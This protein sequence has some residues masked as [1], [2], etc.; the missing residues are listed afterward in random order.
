TR[1]ADGQAWHYVTDH[2]GT[3]QELYDEQREVVWAADLSAYGRTA[4]RLTRVVDNPI[5]FPG[6]YRDE[7]SGLHYNRFRYYD[8]MVG[9]YINQDPIGLIGGVNGYAYADSRPAVAT[10]RFGLATI[11]AG[12]ELGGVAGTAI[13]P[14]PGTILGAA[15]GAIAGAGVMI[16]ASKILKTDDIGT[17]SPT[18]STT[19]ECHRN[20]DCDPCDKK[21]DKS[22]L[23][24][25]G[26][27]GREHEVKQDWMGKKAKISRY[28][29]CGCNDGR[30]VIKAQG[31]KGPIFSETEHMWK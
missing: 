29:L 1:L 7:E 21:L 2:L 6:Q 15:V 23:K 18:D 25:A 22:L 24:S 12:A 3:P 19:K 20:D 14:G 27:A 30:V 10:D 26:I 9:R 31:C 28:D 17:A 5:R 4:R 8:P 13:F 11:A 16:L